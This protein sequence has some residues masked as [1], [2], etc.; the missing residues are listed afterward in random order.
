MK[1]FLT[2]DRDSRFNEILFENR[3][4]SYGAY[5]LRYEEGLI[6]KKSLFIGVAF[7]AAI[8]LTPILINA[9]MV[10][11]TVLPAPPVIHDLTP[12]PIIRDKEPDVIKPAPPV[13]P[14]VNTYDSRVATPTKN[15]REAKPVSPEQKQNAVPGTETSLDNPPVLTPPVEETPPVTAPIVPEVPKKV[16]NNPVSKVDVEAGFQGGINSFRAK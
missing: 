16:D 9:L 10:K 2:S 14:K 5:V 12:I 6:M 3:N 8:A 13:A 7:F 11:E 1:N 4:K 15:A